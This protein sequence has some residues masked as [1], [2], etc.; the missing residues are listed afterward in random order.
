M[1]ICLVFVFFLYLYLYEVLNEIR[2]DCRDNCIIVIFKFIEYVYKLKII[3][4]L[5]EEEYNYI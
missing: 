5:S 4:V 1:C 2:D 3:L